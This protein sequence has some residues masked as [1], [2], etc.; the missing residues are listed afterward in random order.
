MAYSD[1][2]LQRRHIRRDDAFQDRAMAD[3][4][5]R[6]RVPT[7]EDMANWSPDGPPE[8]SMSL[9][10]LQGRTDD[11]NSQRLQKAFGDR[12]QYVPA[13][14]RWFIWT[15]TR[16]EPDNVARV[17]RMAVRELRKLWKQLEREAADC[18]SDELRSVAAFVRRSQDGRRAIDALRL[19]RPFVAV[20]PDQLDSTPH[21]FNVENGT[22]DLRTGEIHAHRQE[23]HITKLAPVSYDPKAVCPTWRRFISEVFRGDDK[24]ASYV[25]RVAGYSMT[26]SVTEHILAFLYGVGSNGKSTFAEMLLYVFGD[27][28]MKA[29]ADLLLARKNDAHPTERADLH[30]KRLV[31]A[32]EAD[33]GRAFAESLLK[34]MTGGDTIRAR[35]MRENFWEFQPSHTIWLAANH[36]PVVRGTDDGLWRRMKLVPFEQQWDTDGTKPNLPKADKQLLQKL[37]AESSGILTWLVEGLRD[38]R[39]N[40]IGTP[41]AVVAATNEYREDSDLI[42][43]FIDEKCMTGEGNRCTSAGLYT[44][45]SAWCL[46]GNLKPMTQ[47]AFGREMES[48]GFARHKSHGNICRLGITVRGTVGDS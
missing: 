32:V 35:R 3:E 12:V 28:G 21:Y 46:A 17:E 15:G 47:T 1:V 39:Q 45:Y 19:L 36:K 41:E 5:E 16:W 6:S 2:E 31:F 20:K 40:G 22:I 30:G 7:D 10:S 37:K 29:P 24:V 11:A 13:W 43:Q 27:Y 44:A 42:G 4:F 8:P 33:A 34:E 48:R 9:L 38:W 26:G 14:D 25:Q 23:D 18:S